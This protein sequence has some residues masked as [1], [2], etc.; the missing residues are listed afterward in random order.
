MG[1]AEAEVLLQACGHPGL[2]SEFQETLLQNKMK[3][4][5]KK[6]TF[7]VKRSNSMS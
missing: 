5:N 4:I 2:V 1:R 3:Q 6:I 7:K